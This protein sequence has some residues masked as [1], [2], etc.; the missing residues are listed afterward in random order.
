MPH[1]TRRRS[2]SRT[3]R[4][5]PVFPLWFHKGSGQWAKGIRGR[6]YYFGTDPD[7]AL[8]EYLRVKDDLEAGRTPRDVQP[9]A[10]TLTTLCNRFLTDSK[11]KRDAG[12]I[13][14]R[15]F[16][17]Y[18]RTCELILDR[19]GK[20][21]VVDQLRP[22]DLMGLR[23]WLSQRRSA[24]PLGNEIGRIRVVLNYAFQSGLVDRPVRY[25]NFKKPA[26]R[27]LRRQRAEAGPRIFEP[28]EIHRL[29][30][31][32]NTQMRAM[33]LLAVNTGC[34]N[35]DLAKMQ[36]R[37]L[38]LES[39]MMDY[40]RPKTGIERRAP[41]WPGTVT[42]VVAWLAKRKP[43][44]DPENENLVFLTKRRGPWSVDTSTRNPI[45]AEFRKLKAKAGIERDG[46]TFYRLRHTTQT[47][48]DE[49]G[50]YLATRR[51]MGHADDSISGHYRERFPDERLIRVSEHV[52][53]WL[54]GG[55]E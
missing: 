45:S 38:D 51:I 42:A 8:T 41:L 14:P 20:T 17:D 52:R 12:E 1:S 44:A 4:S 18:Y 23:R 15:T 49:L 29:L 34:G 35:M 13:T 43:P 25:G 22:D 10:V 40:P 19:L 21:T 33:I 37:H 6:R 48:A 54:H 31:H 53:Q 3:P 11:A 36:F 46:L 30:D 5:K 26:K 32:A 7:Q 39:G 16:G 47:V 27:V 9:D 50:D 2:G 24:V 55:R 28:E